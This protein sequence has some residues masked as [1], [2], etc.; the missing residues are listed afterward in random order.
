MDAR[1]FFMG[2]DGQNEHRFRTVDSEPLMAEGVVRPR[3]V[4]LTFPASHTWN[5]DVPQQRQ[6][7]L[8]FALKGGVTAHR[9]PR[10]ADLDRAVWPLYRVDESEGR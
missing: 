2:G 8:P 4:D 9:V 10:S 1:A 7:A 6:G 5:V 3:P